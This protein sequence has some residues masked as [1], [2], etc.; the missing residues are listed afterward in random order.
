ML[1]R[2]Y[3]M[4]GHEL[5]LPN[6]VDNIK[7]KYFSDIHYTYNF[8]DRKLDAILGIINS[9][10]CDYICIGGDIIDSTNFIRENRKEQ[11]KLLK[12]LEE[13]AKYKKTFISCGNHD[14][15]KRTSNGWSYDYF[16]SFW[17]EVNGI[18]NLQVSHFNP[19]YED[20]KVIIYMPEL[21]YEFYEN[22]NKAENI[23]LLIEKLKKDEQYRVDLNE[24][25]VK[26]LLIHSPYL[27][28]DPKIVELVKE[29][30]IIICG[31]MHKG[32]VMPILDELVK[33][34]RGLVSPYLRPFP[35]NARGVK[36]LN[37]NG[38]PITLIMSGGI[39]KMAS[40]T[41]VKKTLNHLYPLDFED[42]SVLTKKYNKFNK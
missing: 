23:D 14:F 19:Y 7:L 21:D 15:M 6:K 34:N 39:T 26:V 10:F 5:Y 12:W 28:S 22:E 18:S 32:L 33:N 4:N 40:D 24:N 41:F 13:I 9:S 36:F 2:L 38:K 25:K 37:Y 27:L 42:V 16:E 1:D 29:F 3:K 11:I 31:H 30:D 20:D 35:N 8:D 17:K